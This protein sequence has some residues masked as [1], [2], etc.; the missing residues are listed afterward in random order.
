MSDPRVLLLLTQGFED[1]EAASIIAACGWT[2]YRDEIP[3]VQVVTTGFHEEVRGRAIVAECVH[4]RLQ[5]VS[6]TAVDSRG[7]QGTPGE[8]KPEQGNELS[9]A[10]SE[11]RAPSP[12]YR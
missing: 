10:S 7:L 8:S 5:N 4:L 1:L 6:K 9:G 11:S 2:Q 12:T 3:T